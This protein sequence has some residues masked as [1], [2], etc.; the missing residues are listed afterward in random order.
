MTELYCIKAFRAEPST[1]ILGEPGN[2]EPANR[3][4]TLG[5]KQI[6]MGIISSPR[7]VHTLEVPRA[8]AQVM[9]PELQE[10]DHEVTSMFRRY[11][12]VRDFQLKMFVIAGQ[13]G[14]SCP[15]RESR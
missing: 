5:S 4:R 14:E 6:F 12:T 11:L 1:G 13:S 10:I 2:S 7:P 15:K 3:P 9:D 8:T